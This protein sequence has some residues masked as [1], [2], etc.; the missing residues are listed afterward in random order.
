VNR[1]MRATELQGHPVVTVSGDDVAEVRD[2]VYDAGTGSIVGFTLNKRGRFAGRLREMLAVAATRAIGRDAL[3]ID[4]MSSL[5]QPDA[6]PTEISDASSER[7]VIGAAVITKSGTKLGE[8]SDVIVA[9]GRGAQ[10]VGYELHSPD[11]SSS[12]F[13]PLPE[14]ISISG[15]ALIV[16]DEVDAFIHDDLSGFGAA[17]TQFRSQLGE[18]PAG[19][20]LEQHRVASGGG[21]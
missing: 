21:E 12:R 14:Q 16:P 18:Q 19:A 11:G 10:A 7:D 4:D 17:V 5:D 2:V 1:V 9:L 3:V 13:I 8:V 6:A 15:D 20:P